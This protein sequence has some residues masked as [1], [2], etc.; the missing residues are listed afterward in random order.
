M[1]LLRLTEERQRWNLAARTIVLVAARLL[2]KG[3][4]DVSKGR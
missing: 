2:H 3:D 4:P 1:R